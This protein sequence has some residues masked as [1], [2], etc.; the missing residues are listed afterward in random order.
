MV[1]RLVLFFAIFLTGQ[2]MF[3]QDGFI[4]GMVVDSISHEPLT[5]VS[6]VYNE[7]GQGV[8]TNL[9][10][11]FRIPRTNRI[12]FLRLSYV[13]Y[14]SKNIALTPAASL[15]NLIISLSPDPYD[16]AEVVVYPSENPAH[17]IIELATTNR[18][19]NNPEK[20]GPF[21]YISYDKLVFG[22]D[23]DSSGGATAVD[24]LGTLPY[25]LPDT[26]PYGMDRKGRIDT[27][28]FLEKQYLFI[29]ESV[30]SRKYFSPEENKEEII[31]SKVS[32]VSQPSF[33]VMARQFQSFSFYENFV[34]IANRQFLNPISTGSTD[35]YF[36]LIQDTVY[37]EQ[38]DTVFIISFRPRK[39]KNFNG[40]KGVLYINS[41]GYAIQNVLAEANDEKGSPFKV[42]IQ[43]Q[44]DFIEGTRWFPVLLNTTISF[45]ASQ[46][47]NDAM[48]VNIIG[49]GKSYIVNINFHPFYD[50]SE[51]SSVQIEVSP[52]AHKQPDQVWN[53]YRVDSLSSREQETYRVIDSIGK[54]E[55]LDRTMTSFETLLTGYLPGRYWNF[56][57]RRF[58]DYNAY[59]GL[60]LGAGG[61]TT[62]QLS[63][64]L[65]LGG[66]FAYSFR[67]DAFK[68]SGSV[69]FNL[70][71]KQELE[72][73]LYYLDDV[74]ESGGVRF[75]ETWSFS[76]TSFLRNYMLEVM[77]LTKEAGVSLSFRAF[78]YLT[79]QP[80]LYHSYLMP[81]N[82]Y[83]YSLS[84]E[85]PQ[86][87]V[88]DFYITETGIRLKYAFKESFMKTPRGNKFSMGTRY[89]VVY[90][91]AGRGLSWFDGEFNYWRTEM[92]ITKV[93]TTKA[94]GDTRLAMVTGLVTDGVPYSK[95]YAGMGSYKPFTLEAEQSFGTMRF[96]EF[97][98]DRFMALFIKQDF[99][100]LLFKG[101]GKLQP[102]IALVQ[103]IGYGQLKSTAHHENITYSTMEQGYFESGL[104]INN[105]FRIQIFRYGIGVF[106]RY[107][108]YALSETIDNFAFKLS[109]Q[110][111][112][113]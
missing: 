38:R 45:N 32:G 26:L 80:Y 44:Y 101:R 13:G 96:N 59:E 41:N 17:R 34:N 57:L 49:T 52:D 15:N 54:A 8:V 82:G 99:G 63:R 75:N 111:N 71:Q 50:K 7:S 94:L 39:G 74:R 64:L 103:N 95:L 89:P 62:P 4:T 85:N 37:T 90:F 88:S 18:N 68:Y 65:T 43:Q 12:N 25:N 100:K 97:L 46:F 22:V 91:N 6:I 93:F 36:F 19:K 16:I 81:T 33:V 60:R 51:F 83:G 92:K 72:L 67:D 70:W 113:K 23:P 47:G 40:M 55:H 105:I 79:A 30:S 2:W 58:I 9:E 69:T 87:I 31:A 109:L 35:K 5:F 112:L 53:S 24:S 56:D 107:G 104:L 21:S 28:R 102:E 29:M 98:S 78:K 106:Y 86:V 77:D 84:D 73:T 108:P 110:F 61:R 66:Y 48:P 27:R 11:N 42:S 20:S 10:G 76:G 1:R 14:R 3:S